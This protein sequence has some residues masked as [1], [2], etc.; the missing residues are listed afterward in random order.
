MK[1]QCKIKT[2][3]QSTGVDTNLVQDGRL[4]K[5]NRRKTLTSHHFRQ[6]AEETFLK[7]NIFRVSKIKCFSPPCNNKKY[8]FGILEVEV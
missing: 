3:V 1:G 7:V 4:S 8:I 2:T 6:V 5:F